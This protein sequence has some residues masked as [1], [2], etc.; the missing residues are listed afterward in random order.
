MAHAEHQKHYK[1][2]RTGSIVRS[3]AI[4][5]ARTGQGGTK[6]RRSQT[7]ARDRAAHIGSDRNLRSEPRRGSKH[8]QAQADT[9]RNPA[10][11]Q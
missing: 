2:D 4:S 6:P 5:R 9:P 3:R 11:K 1:L 7:R 10:L 8:S